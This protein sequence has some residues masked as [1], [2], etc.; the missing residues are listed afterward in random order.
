MY[1]HLVKIKEGTQGN[2]KM[3][4]FIYFIPQLTLFCN[5][6]YL[7]KHIFQLLNAKT[8]RNSS[9]TGRKLKVL[10]LHLPWISVPGYLAAE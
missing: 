9:S 5:N 8:L 10:G 7:P 1:N 4:L 2:L 3:M 6:A